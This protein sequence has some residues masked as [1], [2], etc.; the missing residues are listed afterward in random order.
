MKNRIVSVAVAAVPA[1]A[2]I[3]AGWVLLLAPNAAQ[4][5][6]AE[7][8]IGRVSDELLVAQ[9]QLSRAREFVAGGDQARIELEALREALPVTPDV[10]GFVTLND[11]LARSHGVEILSLVPEQPDTGTDDEGFALDDSPPDDAGDPTGSSLGDE[12]SDIGSAPDDSNL[13]GYGAADGTGSGGSLEL[14]SG[15]DSFNVTVSARGP[16][17]RLPAYI[18]SLSD[19]SRLVLIEELSTVSEGDGQTA[20]TLRLAVLYQSE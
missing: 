2:V 20:A 11:E 16:D 18:A 13:D 5:S 17:F 3:V 6:E 7:A 1:L 10:G 19:L 8:E 4:Q 12:V 15:V 14:P 9:T